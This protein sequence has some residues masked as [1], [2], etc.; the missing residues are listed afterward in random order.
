MILQTVKIK[1]SISR[2]VCVIEVLTPLNHECIGYSFA[3]RF[4]FF[5]FCHLFLLSLFFNNKNSFLVTKKEKKMR[6]RKETLFPV[7]GEEE[8]K[9]LESTTIHWRIKKPSIFLLLKLK[10]YIYIT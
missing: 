8:L 5:T 9:S 10:Y 2:H 1:G 6:K 4:I 3:F 7:K